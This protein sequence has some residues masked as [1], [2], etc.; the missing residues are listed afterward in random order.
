[1]TTAPGARPGNW[2][3]SIR[4]YGWVDP[5]ITT[6][7]AAEYAAGLLKTRLTAAREIVEFECEYL[8]GVWR[9][10]LVT[11]V[12]PTGDPVTV[13]IKSFSGSFDNV[14]TFGDAS[15]ADGVWRPC[16]YIGEVGALV[17]PL[18]VYGVSLRTIAANWHTL[19]ALSKQ[20]IMPGGDVLARRPVLNQ[21]EV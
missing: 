10:D 1:V 8:P 18:D 7:G 4:K 2:L 13:R 9:G 14:G 3:G 15:S 20:R 6:I 19:K 21:Q 17:C 16:T 12:R 11:L 5:A